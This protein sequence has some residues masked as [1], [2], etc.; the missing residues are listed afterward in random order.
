MLKTVPNAYFQG[1][2]DVTA[3]E[4]HQNLGDLFLLDVRRPDELIGELGHIQGSLHIVLDELPIRIR[5]LPTDKEIVIVCRSGQRSAHAASFLK[6][7]GYATVY[8]LQ[9]GMM[10]WIDS[11]F[12]ITKE[13][14]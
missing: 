6:D 2:L 14:F 9:G 12:A 1:V 10:S 11:G 4:V 5:E 3:E 7:Q 8:N 13:G